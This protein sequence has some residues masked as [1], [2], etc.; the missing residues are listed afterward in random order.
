MTGCFHPAQPVLP[1]QVLGIRTVIA[2][3]GFA[4]DPA[5]YCPRFDDELARQHA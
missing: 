5:H 1:T 3:G 2:R 4:T